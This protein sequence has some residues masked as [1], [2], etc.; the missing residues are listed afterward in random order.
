MAAMLDCCEKNRI[1]F[2][3][4]V[5]D[6]GGTDASSMNQS[7]FGVRTGGIVVVARYAHCQSSVASKKDIEA[8]IDLIN[9]FSRH[10]FFF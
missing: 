1:P 7:G 6:K 8:G 4:E 5:I 3:R 9:A 2:Q 10:E